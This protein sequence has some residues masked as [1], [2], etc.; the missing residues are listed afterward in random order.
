MDGECGT[1][2]GDVESGNFN[3]QRFT[4]AQMSSMHGTLLLSVVRSHSSRQGSDM[5]STAVTAR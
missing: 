2:D 5:S 4:N 3:I 1:G